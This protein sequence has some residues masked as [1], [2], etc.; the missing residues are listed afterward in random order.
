MAFSSGDAITDTSDLVRAATRGDVSAFPALVIRHQD[1]AVGY[2]YALLGDHHLAEDA[3]Q[4]AFVEMRTALSQ[5]ENPDAFVPWL[6]RI[7]FK[8]V[9]RIRRKADFKH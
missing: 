8:Y 6:K 9:D 7:V 4:D 5:L 2:A 3:A 1:L